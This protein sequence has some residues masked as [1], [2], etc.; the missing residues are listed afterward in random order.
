MLARFFFS[1]VGRLSSLFSRSE[2]KP[3]HQI[4][5]HKK[6]LVNP[7]A[8]ADNRID[9]LIEFVVEYMMCAASELQTRLL[10]YNIAI[11]CTD[12]RNHDRVSL[13]QVSP[14]HLL[15]QKQPEARR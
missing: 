9:S 1:E 10:R 13:D 12:R 14:T 4:Q 15:H 2:D 3:L 8:S 6:M 7:S 11:L 5:C